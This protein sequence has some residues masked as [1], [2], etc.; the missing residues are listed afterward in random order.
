MECCHPRNCMTGCELIGLTVSTILGI[1]VGYLFAVGLIP[2]TINFIRI[3][4]VMSVIG[5][6]IL[7]VSLFSASKI[8]ACREFYGCICQSSKL[9]L[10]GSVGTLLTTTIASILGVGIISLLTSIVVGL[11]AFFFILMMIS[12]ICIVSCIIKELCQK[13]FE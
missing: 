7:I 10:A 8:S 11:S 4:L 5:L 3:A 13:D 12:I 9:L 2:V 1:A 6:A